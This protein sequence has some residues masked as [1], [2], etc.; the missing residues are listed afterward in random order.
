M[1]T[2][3]LDP[4]SDTFHTDLRVARTKLKLTQQQLANAVGVNQRTVCLWEAAPGNTGRHRPRGKSLERLR[5]FL[6][7]PLS[8][9]SGPLTLARAKQLLATSL[10]VPESAIEIIVKY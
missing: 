6:G 9:D 10:G 4:E 5:E 3:L 1:T 7:E 8:I 2:Q